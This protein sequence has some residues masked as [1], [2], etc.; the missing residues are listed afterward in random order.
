[1][2][3]TVIHHRGA[4]N[5]SISLFTGGHLMQRFD[6]S[7]MNGEQ[8]SEAMSLSIAW[9]QQP[10]PVDKTSNLTRRKMRLLD[11]VRMSERVKDYAEQM[12]EVQRTRKERAAQAKEAERKQLR[13]EGKARGKRFDAI[14]RALGGTPKEV[15]D[16]SVA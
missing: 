3:R 8:R 6:I 5:D 7:E 12:T 15:D 13:E 16:D 9:A 14:E 11:D 10:K 4:G 2:E 1:M